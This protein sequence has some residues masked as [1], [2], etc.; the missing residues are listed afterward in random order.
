MKKIL[1]ATD[2]S[3]SAREAVRFGLELAEE[4]G[5]EVVLGHAVPRSTCS[6]A[7][8]GAGPPPWSTS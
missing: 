6:R 7:A 5:A 8:A 1:I 4:Q 3:P 2:G